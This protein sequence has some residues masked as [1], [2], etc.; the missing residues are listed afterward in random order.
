MSAREAILGQIREAIHA[1][2]NTEVNR[3]YQTES[4]LS[5]DG[6]VELFTQRVADYRAEVIRCEAIK[7]AETIT[8]A[9]SGMSSSQVLLGRGLGPHWKVVGTEDDNFTTS[10]LDWFKAVVTTSEVSI[11]ETGTIVLDHQQNGQG[12]RAL[13]L[14]PDIHICIVLASQIVHSV[15]EAIAKLD[16]KRHQTW[17][18]GPSATSDIELD[19]VEGVHGPRDFQ[20]ILITDQ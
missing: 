19:R 14:I 6:I 17:I 2:P 12:R 15:P 10:E 13:S 1:M 16:P 8:N 7:A 4:H 3:N 11:A 18:S 5:H 9:L 20:V